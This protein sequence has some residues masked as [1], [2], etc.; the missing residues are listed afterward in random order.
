MTSPESTLSRV[1]GIVSDW[2]ADTELSAAR[3]MLD[4]AKLLGVNPPVPVKGRRTRRGH[5]ENL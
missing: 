4:L 5:G 3:C 2:R 1:I